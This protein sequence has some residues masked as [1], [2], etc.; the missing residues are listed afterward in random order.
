MFLTAMFTSADMEVLKNY[1]RWICHSLI[2]IRRWSCREFD[3]L[4]SR[5]HIRRIFTTNVLVLLKSRMD[6]RG[7]YFY[8]FHRTGP[9]NRDICVI[10]QK[11]ISLEK[12]LLHLYW[13]DFIVLYK[14]SWGMCWNLYGTSLFFYRNWR[15]SQMAPLSLL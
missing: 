11:G 4:Y 7:W 10:L 9:E 5:W 13:I 12:L 2:C 1:L 15:S 14:I 3:H 8:H 6:S